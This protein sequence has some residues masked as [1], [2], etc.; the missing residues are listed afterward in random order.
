MTDHGPPPA[1]GASLPWW[2]SA[3]FS[4]VAVVLVLAVV[5][6]SLA[7][8]GVRPIADD[9]DPYVGFSALAPLFIEKPGADGEPLMVT[10]PNKRLAFNQQRFPRAKR[11]GAVRIFCLGGSTTYGRPYEHPTSFPGWMEEFLPALDSTRSWEV[12]N[13]GGIS[14]AS[15][16]IA[17]LTKELARL[18]PDLFVIYT[19]HNEF[20]ERRTY[21]RLMDTP[22]VVR[23]LGSLASRTRIWAALRTALVRSDGP[24]AGTPEAPEKD[25]LPSEVQARLDRSVGPADYHRDDELQGRVLEHYRTSLHRMI[26]T[27]KDAGARVILVTPA[28][29]LGDCTPFKSE[30]REGLLEEDVARLRRLSAEATLAQD[31]GR[32]DEALQRLDDAVA[33][34]DRHAHTHFQRGRVLASLGRGEEAYAAFVRA[35]DEDVC[36]LRALSATIDIAREV[37]AESGVPLVDFVNV[38]ESGAPGGAP[39]AD[40][41]LDHVHPTIRGNRTIALAVLKAMADEGI[42]PAAADIDEQTIAAV[43][44][45][46]EAKV[47]RQTHGIALMNLSK[48]L[49]WAGKFEE[50]DRL[51]LEAA[52]LAPGIPGVHFQ[53]ALRAVRRNDVAAAV[54]HYRRTIEKDPTFAKAYVNLG[55]LYTNQ[56]DLVSAVNAFRE[57][58]AVL[59]DDAELRYSLGVVL[60]Q[61]RK[62]PAARRELEEAVRLDPRNDEARRLLGEATARA[63]G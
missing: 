34:D 46:V 6:G 60:L 21:G 23:S 22:G 14:Y 62:Y 44:E 54:Q 10:A 38:V 50:A 28:S 9:E 16:R 24:T 1:V 30:F 39:G 55:V 48:V 58:L 33:I 18:E 20:L 17:E 32:P 57:G 25:I 11:D 41:F 31:A 35:R 45:R 4:L 5:E 3:L 27:A 15:Y 47:N 2:K 36:P 59:P 8:F 52:E 13:A 26:A 63:G 40:A 19:G 56:F 53:L 43:T 12:V 51:A 61:Q 29:N 49:G 42:V 7:L 37:A